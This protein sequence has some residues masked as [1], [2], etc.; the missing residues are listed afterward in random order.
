M[1]LIDN[2]IDKL[3]SKASGLFNPFK[4]KIKDSLNPNATA[5]E[6]EGIGA[7]LGIYKP[8]FATKEDAEVA[9]FTSQ[10][11]PVAEDSPDA[12]EFNKKEKKKGQAEFG[13]RRHIRKFVRDEL[14][15]REMNRG[16]YYTAGGEV[17]DEPPVGDDEPYTGTV[18]KGPKTAWARVC[19]NR[20]GKSNGQH[21]EGFVL[22]GVNNFKDIYGF[23]EDYSKESS[24]NVL[25]Y[26]VNGKPH[27]LEEKDFL[28]RPAPGLVS[29]D[30]EVK[31]NKQNGRVTTLK[32]T[33]HSRAQLDYLH[34]YFFSP[35]LTVVGEW[36]W[37]NYTTG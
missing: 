31:S 28:F 29:F 3:K 19:S 25:G 23:D 9:L 22:N 30:S 11:E 32:I 36:G 20:M 10:P 34:D 12:S 21:F 13:K 1:G 26:D 27:T 33:C 24:T 35:G 18:Y 14:L 17:Q 4:E 2:E 15:R 8:Q 6:D 7:E 5:L 37:N 16:L